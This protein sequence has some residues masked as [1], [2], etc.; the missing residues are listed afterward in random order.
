MSH[1]W[2]KGHSIKI[3]WCGSLI[4]SGWTCD[5]DSVVTLLPDVSFWTGKW[6]MEGERS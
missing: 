5:A 2:P 1:G 6:E 4:H 3:P